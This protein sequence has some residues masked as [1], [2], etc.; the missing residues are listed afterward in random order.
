MSKLATTEGSK[1]TIESFKDDLVIW[2]RDFH[3]HPELAFEEERTSER[4]LEL[5]RSFG[6]EAEKGLAGTGVVGTI[7]A[8]SSDRS[9]ALRADMDALP[10]EEENDFTHRSR[11]PGKMHACG[12]DGHTTMLLGAARYLAQN[13]HFDGVVHFIFQPAEE[14]DGGAKVMIDDG[15]FD[16]FPAERVFGM[17]NMP[18]LSVG[19]FSLCSGPM[20]AAIDIIGMSVRSPGG[21]AAFP[22]NCIDTPLTAAQLLVNL[23]SIV[24]RNVDPLK[25]AVISVTKVHGGE[26]HNVLP[27]HVRMEGCVRTFLPRVQELIE[28]RMGEIGEGV[29]GA[30]GAH[31][32]LD[33]Q[34]YYPA[35]VNS[36]AEVHQ[37][38]GAAGAVGDSVA[39]D[40]TPIMARKTS[41]SCC[42]RSRAPSS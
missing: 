3:E 6:V 28:R 34:R 27:A 35:T 10:I 30:H 25:Q 42:R 37:A 15:L 36:E 19:N 38:A 24:A 40:M 32:E 9:I 7:K 22:H 26:T 20:L 14:K 29:C 1:A 18:G 8:G 39:T 4:V 41:P 17:H 12:H 16:K 31:F 23:Q 33:Y 21:H 2:R 11:H 13:R 5:L